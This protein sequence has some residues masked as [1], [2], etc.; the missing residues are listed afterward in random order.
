MNA[1]EQ[2][3]VAAF[4]KKLELGEDVRGDIA[5][6]EQQYP[7]SVHLHYLVGYYHEREFDMGKAETQYLKC[8]ELQ[9][10][11]ASAYFAL[12]QFYLSTA[13]FEEAER[14]L[15]QLYKN[16]DTKDRICVCSMLCPKYANMHRH[17]DVTK[18]CLPIIKAVTTTTDE[19]NASIRHWQGFAH[20]CLAA[21]NAI[22][23][24]DAEEALP[25]YEIGMKC[26]GAGA[27]AGAVYDKIKEAHS[28][29]S[30]YTLQHQHQHGPRPKS[31]PKGMTPPNIINIA[32]LS[33]NYNLCSQSRFLMPFFTD[34]D[35]NKFKVFAYYYNDFYDEVSK[36]LMSLP[37][38]T[39]V[40]LWNMPPEQI[41]FVMRAHAIDVLVHLGTGSTPQIDDGPFMLRYLNNESDIGNNL[42]C[43]DPRST[44]PPIQCTQKTDPQ[45]VNI[46][47]LSSTV[48]QH[49]L[50]RGIWKAILQGNP[51]IVLHVKLGEHEQPQERQKFADFPPDQ[52]RFMPFVKEYSD[53]LAELNRLDCVAD[54]YPVCSKSSACAALSMGLPVFTIQRDATQ[55]TACILFNTLPSLGDACMC[56]SLKSYR[57]RLSSFKPEAFF[58]AGHSRQQIRSAFIQAQDP[59]KFMRSYE[60]RLHSLLSPNTPKLELALDGV[61]VCIQGAGQHLHAAIGELTQLGAIITPADRLRAENPVNI[62]LDGKDTSNIDPSVHQFAFFHSP[63]TTALE[64]SL[65]KLGAITP[66]TQPHHEASFKRL[67]ITPL[68]QSSPSSF[69]DIAHELTK[70]S[71]MHVITGEALLHH[72]LIKKAYTATQCAGI[73]FFVIPHDTCDII[74]LQANY[75]NTF[76]TDVEKTLERPYVLVTHNSDENIDQQYAPYADRP[77]LR[78]WFAQNLLFVHPKAFCLPIGIANSSWPHGDRRALA[79]AEKEAAAGAVKSNLCYLGSDVKTNVSERSDTLNLQKFYVW[80]DQQMAYPQ[81]LKHLASF[82]FCICP[83]GKGVDTHRF[84][85]CVYLGVV[86]IVKKSVWTAVCP[87]VQMLV[88][89]HWQEATMERL[90]SYL[91]ESDVL[92]HPHHKNLTDVRH[93]KKLIEDA[94]KAPDQGPPTQGWRALPL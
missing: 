18:L 36:H 85:E 15:L 94:C 29:A 78:A 52:V 32:Y 11:F 28:R 67:S 80:Q 68:I 48:K 39:F 23:Q 62:C 43:Y 41:S 66:I 30:Y 65:I 87:G 92:T 59:A 33:A 42:F 84:W 79:A 13:L 1:Q 70:P 34:Y 60:A 61:R 46:G 64:M 72:L 37:G 4:Q 71:P 51:H 82:K 8:I 20:L 55:A 90:E 50:V 12:C 19:R 93:Y 57:E 7:D 49:A 26:G 91:R 56:K 54:T 77:K 35:K 58:K 47:V 44:A 89:D 86:P 75:V 2:N 16:A 27:G 14:L 88:V 9:P 74:F 3:L 21:G 63:P 22:F 76:F 53:F 17:S 25:I 69:A 40:N 73:T 38:V 31:M 81:Y 45:T 5:I 6:I 10:Q 24:T 83:A